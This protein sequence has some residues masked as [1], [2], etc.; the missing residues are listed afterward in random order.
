MKMEIVIIAN[1]MMNCKKYPDDKNGELILGKI[2]GEIKDKGKKNK[3]DCVVGVSG[4]CDSSF[5]LVKCLEHG[6]RPLAVHFFDNTFNSEIATQNIK[7][8][9]NKLNVDLYTHVV[10]A[11]EY[12]DMSNLFCYQ[13]QKI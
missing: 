13:E 1:N 2:F 5:L 7:N 6:L 9:L 12:E 11:T 3:Y 10:N 4:G 8:L